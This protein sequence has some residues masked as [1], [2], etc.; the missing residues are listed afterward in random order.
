VKTAKRAVLSHRGRVGV[1]LDGGTVARMRAMWMLVAATVASVVVSG[2][3]TEE[4]EPDVSR[5]A[6]Q[7]A[8]QM[9]DTERFP[10]RELSAVTAQELT[11]AG[12][13]DADGDTPTGDGLFVV[14]SGYDRTAM[15]LVDDADTLRV[16][17]DV[18]GEGCATTMEW[19]GDMVLVLTGIDPD[20]PVEVRDVPEDC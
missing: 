8:C 18:P 20:L 17:V 6:T 1:E 15:R 9:L 10:T 14:P 12:C 3:S 4:P 13:V 5:S 2:C 7:V 11:D 16:E 19:R